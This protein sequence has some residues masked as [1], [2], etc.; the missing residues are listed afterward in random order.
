MSATSHDSLTAAEAA[1]LIGWSPAHLARKRMTGEGPAFLKLA[2]G[3]QGR[4]RY[5][6]ADVDSW[7]ASHMRTSTSDRG[8]Q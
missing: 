2:R 5:R 3:K 8:G 7:L 4:V 1:A 6:R